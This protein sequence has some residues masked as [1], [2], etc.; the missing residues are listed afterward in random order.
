MKEKKQQVKPHMLLA[1]EACF[2]YTYRKQQPVP[3]R[4][5]VL[6]KD[7]FVLAIKGSTAEGSKTLV[8]PGPPEPG[9]KTFGQWMAQPKAVRESGLM[10]SPIKECVKY[11]EKS[12]PPEMKWVDIVKCASQVDWYKNRNKK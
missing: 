8:F 12:T 9:T 10:R 11:F 4:V 6:T 1:A 5:L 7:G 2:R 3:E